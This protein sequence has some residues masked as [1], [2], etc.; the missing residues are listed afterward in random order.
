MKRIRY[1]KNTDGTLVSTR[2]I[3]TTSGVVAVTLNTTSKSFSV[4]NTAENKV[5][6]NGEVSSNI[7]GLKNAVKKALVGL[8]A[9]FEAETRN[10][11]I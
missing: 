10:R 6:L 9:N 5:V 1:T 2:P 8:G 7:V 11:S 3:I 4:V